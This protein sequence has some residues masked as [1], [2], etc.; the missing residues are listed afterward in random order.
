MKFKLTKTS[1]M[2]SHKIEPKE[3][4]INTLE[5][6]A[7]VESEYKCRMVISFGNKTIEIYDDYRE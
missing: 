6:L 1:D 4:E 3:I 7:I 2:F 5:D